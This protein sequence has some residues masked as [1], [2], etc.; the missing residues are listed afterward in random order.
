M[1]EKGT[2]L[3]TLG[4][5][6]GGSSRLRVLGVREEGAC[7]RVPSA[8]DHCSSPP[9]SLY[10][11]FFFFS[12]RRWVSRR[13]S[14]SVLGGHSCGID[15]SGGSCVAGDHTQASHMQSKHSALCAVS[16]SQFIRDLM[17]K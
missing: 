9:C 12:P 8:H 6:G 15:G 3:R 11:C 16:L 7:L 17:K 4:V 10:K 5:V 14:S 1:R 13:T 2:G